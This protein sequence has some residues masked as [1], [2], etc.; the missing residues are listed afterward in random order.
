MT[1]RRWMM[2]SEKLHDLFSSQNIIRMI[3]SRRLRK[4]ELVACTGETTNADRVL[5]GKP[6]RK[7]YLEDLGVYGRTRI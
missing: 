6:K 2:H 3:K 1:D 5:V 7:N 4:A